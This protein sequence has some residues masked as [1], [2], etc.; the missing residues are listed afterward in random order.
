MDTWK[1]TVKLHSHSP[2][3]VL[4]LQVV[5]SDVLGIILIVDSVSWACTNP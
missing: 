2:D 3:I 4:F 5:D 1:N